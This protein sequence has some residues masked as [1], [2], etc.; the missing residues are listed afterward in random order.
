[1]T[2]NGSSESGSSLET[3]TVTVDEEIGGSQ[4]GIK[5]ELSEGVSS[6]TSSI[7]HGEEDIEVSSGSSI[8]ELVVGVSGFLTK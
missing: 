1:M 8:S 7:D 2:T 6:G 5:W 3:G 4:R